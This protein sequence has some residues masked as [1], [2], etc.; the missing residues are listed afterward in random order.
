MKKSSHPSENPFL[1]F[2]IHFDSLLFSLILFD[3]SW[4]FI[5]SF[6]Y[7]ILRRYRYYAVPAW[8]RHVHPFR[9]SFLI[10]WWFTVSTF[11]FDMNSTIF[12]TDVHQLE[13]V[14][15]PRTCWPLPQVS[16]IPILL[17]IIPHIHPRPGFND[18][19][20][21]RSSRYTLPNF[22]LFRDHHAVR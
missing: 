12:H 5:H 6:R 20:L 18:N 21:G 16:R 2:F 13:S 14:R 17:K 19:V 10:M 7:L 22:W 4:L 3:L 9:V 11:V 8:S 1:F 15:F